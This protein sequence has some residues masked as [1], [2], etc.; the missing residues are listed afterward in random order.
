[1]SQHY[2][3]ILAL[4]LEYSTI[5][6]ILFYFIYISMGLAQSLGSVVQ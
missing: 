5:N 2:I 6:G 4:I 1:M 3:S